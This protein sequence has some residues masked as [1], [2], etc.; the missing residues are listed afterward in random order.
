MADN[1]KNEPVEIDDWLDDFEESDNTGAS[2]DQSDLDS[3]LSD[4]NP[5][6]DLF[7]EPEQAADSAEEEVTQSDIDA[8]FGEGEIPKA[9]AAKA[10]P[11]KAAAGD[12]VVS[13]DDID[14]LFG[15][16]AT[17]A[18]GATDTQSTPDASASLSQEDLDDLLDE[19]QPA[20]DSA[21]EEP[22]A[23]T[24]SPVKQEDIDALFGDG[25]EAEPE[26]AGAEEEPAAADV[27]P[28]KQE[29][30]DA[31][32][33]EGQEE[34]PLEADGFKDDTQNLSESGLVIEH[35]D[36]NPKEPPVEFEMIVD[37]DEAPS[38][39]GAGIT[40]NYEEENSG[41]PNSEFEMVTDD[42][43]TLSR[44]DLDILISDDELDL[45]ESVLDFDSSADEEDVSSDQGEKDTMIVGGNPM[46]SIAADEPV[47]QS[48]INS[49]FGDMSSSG[50][51][52]TVTQKV[53]DID[54][55]FN[56]FTDAD[57]D[58]DKTFQSEEV[59]FTDLLADDDDDEESF[60]L[61]DDAAAP[62]AD[63]FTLGTDNDGETV[64]AASIFSGDDDETEA[65]PDFLAADAADDD[66]TI[67]FL[68][69][70]KR[71]LFPPIPA[72][73][74]N[75]K[76]VG[77]AAM[78]ALLLLIGGYY[79]MR[80]G[81][82]P[83]IIIPDGTQ[84]AALNAQEEEN[85]PPRALG[86]DYKMPTGG[87]ELDIVLTAE[88]AENDPLT[89]KIT[90][91]PTHGRI[92]GE[93]PN[94]TYLPNNN[95][96]G[97]DR[98]SFLVSDAG[99]ISEPTDIVIS[100]PN[101]AG[102]PKDVTVAKKP[103]PTG[104]SAKNITIALRSSESLNLDW[105]KIWKKANHAPFGKNVSV[106]I[107]GKKLHGQLAK[108]NTSRHR[109][110]P[111][112]YFSGNEEIKYRFKRGKTY[113]KPGRIRLVMTSD[114]PPPK[115]VL[116]PLAKSY[117][118]GELVTLDA[119]ATQDDDR[120]TLQFSWEQTGG[121]PIRLKQLNKE[122]SIVSFVMPSSFYRG[123]TAGPQIMLTAIDESGQKHQ[124]Q[125]SLHTISKQ[126]TALWRGNPGGSSIAVEPDCPQGHCPGDK[127]PWPYPN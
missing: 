70:K 12:G 96:P 28:V 84:E 15:E 98:F 125:I 127:L 75:K 2:V 89:F 37:D 32:F 110:Q 51:T 57:T 123:T 42:S 107:L 31:L 118:V 86:S 90:S 119:S 43:G 82:Q 48:E 73:L 21:A 53:E 99:G 34:T 20:P 71:G 83:A 54:Q 117:R 35:H 116:G 58:E 55:L 47:D 52:E 68:N 9:G 65:L 36:I 61:G 45:N 104:I 3:L 87:G 126:H 41:G 59:D 60:S 33:G 76:V 115:I 40:I 10:T 74:K 62:S 102:K 94:I 16:G 29:D 13:Q 92:S 111:D 66:E 22:P 124:Q 67:T 46:D 81:T 25:E 38:Q 100:G 14:A 79:Y 64:D 80:P 49:L 106:Q 4:D 97:E 93:P 108:I 27:A 44:E 19:E 18:P 11:E 26:A 30:I 120:R 113:S 95:F 5:E 39:N 8:L 1:E 72:L 17:P 7:S 91:G 122:G 63:T 103:K 78:L 50:V 24:A 114:A 112:R 85:T 105:R 109:Y 56:D 101:L 69:E 88:D 23:K 121:T 77:I 6:D